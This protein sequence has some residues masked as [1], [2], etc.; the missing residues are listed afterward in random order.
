MTDL[1]PTR[2]EGDATEI[3]RQDAVVRGTPDDGPLDRAQLD[4]FDRDGYL[5]FE[6]LVTPEEVEQFRGE[7]RRLAADPAVRADERTIIEGTSQE[8]RTIF[9]VHRTSEVFARIAAD[10]RLVGRAR[11]VLGSDV[12]IHQSRVNLKP[13]FGGGDFAWH[14]DFE[15]WHAEDGLPR[16]RTVSISVSL[17]DNYSFNGPL[18]IMPGTHKTFVSCSGVTPEDN[19]KR[20]LVMQNA[21]VPSEEILTRM[22]DEHGI[23]VLAGTAGSAVM[24]DCNCMHGSNG[25]ISPYP[26][27]NI[28]LVY[29][30]VE[31]AAVEPFA[32]DRPRPA[33]LGARDVTPV[34]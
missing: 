32:A 34:G 33:Y 10:P 28:F 24:F 13:G 21:G 3:P 16:M 11:Q 12:Y 4:G 14:S 17:T 9:E 25:N 7:L 8:V 1:Y 26:R 27:S 29:N 22:A 5:T 15:T 19:Y 30:S 2:V 20:S 23:D 18:M 6:D 31:N